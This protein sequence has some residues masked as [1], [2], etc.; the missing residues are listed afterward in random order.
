MISAENVKNFLLSNILKPVE[1]KSG[2]TILSIVAF[3][4]KKIRGL[5]PYNE[6]G[7]FVP[8][9]YRRNDGS[10]DDPGA[11]CLYLP[12]TSEKARWEGV[13]MYGF[14]KFVADIEFSHRGHSSTDIVQ[15]DG[16]NIVELSVRKRKAKIVASRLFCYTYK[17]GSILKTLI[18]MEGYVGIGHEA[19]EVN[20]KLGD[21]MVSDEI[22]K[23]DLSSEAIDY[24]YIPKMYSLLHKPGEFLK[25]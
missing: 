24:G 17:N 4:Y 15:H 14:P 9:N 7:T 20:L 3:E 22:R 10:M 1:V 5:K 11:Y 6:F 23:L 13:N 2:L 25:A 16:K 21:H 18:E 8:V 19:G 12:V